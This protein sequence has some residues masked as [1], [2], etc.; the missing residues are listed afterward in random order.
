MG[1]VIVVGSVNVDLVVRAPRL[2]GPGETV[3]GGTFARHGG[4]KGANQAVAA[5]R[6]GARTHL[7]GCLGDDAY[8]RQLRKA[9]RQAGVRLRGVEEVPGPSGVAIILVE[10]GGQNVIAV[11]PGA[12]ASVSA[13]QVE[14]APSLKRAEVVVAQLE[15][16]IESVTAAA[17]LGRQHGAY[18]ILNAAPARTDIGDLLAWVDVLVVNE[19]EL[20][21]LVH[22]SPPEGDEGLAAREL[23]GR[24][25]HA[26]VVTLGARGAVV[27]TR[28][29]ITR[30][31]SPSVEVVDTTAAGD[32]FVG[33]LAARLDS[34]DNLEHA[35]R[36]ATAAGALAC[37]RMGAQPS[38][39]TAADVDRLLAS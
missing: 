7:I 38:L 26:V 20:A 29:Q 6:L 5:A 33:A 30:V 39:P 1:R 35:V 27:V 37:T 16:P 4:G 19:L 9:L 25:P 2:P 21:A 11:A 24:G 3:T 10:Q 28:Q 14:A 12:N 17:R 18:S 8:G 22:G 32:A 36:Y 34:I 31:P 13:E 15:T 23:L